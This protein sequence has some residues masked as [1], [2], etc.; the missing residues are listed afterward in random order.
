MESVVGMQRPEVIV[1]R[2]ERIHS[3]RGIGTGTWR[4]IW[5]TIRKWLE[6]L[7]VILG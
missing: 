7:K 4:R 2:W 6:T 3:V 5:R 1:R